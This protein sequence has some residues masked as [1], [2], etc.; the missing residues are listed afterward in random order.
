M[1]F[2][3]LSQYVYVEIILLVTVFTQILKRYLKGGRTKLAKLTPKWLTLLTAVFF[4]GVIYV[5][6][7]SAFDEDVNVLK[8]ILSFGISIVVY[9]YAW[10]PLQDKIK[11]RNALTEEDDIYKK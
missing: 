5:F 11:G 4:F 10:K 8:Y 1:D 2:T 6:R 9:D 7:K 3:W